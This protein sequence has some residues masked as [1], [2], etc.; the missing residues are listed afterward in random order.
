MIRESGLDN[1]IDVFANY[2]SKSRLRIK[3][4]VIENGAHI[5]TLMCCLRGSVSV[6]R[7]L[8]P[9]VLAT[10]V[11]AKRLC[12]PI[13]SKLCKKQLLLYSPHSPDKKKQIGG[14]PTKMPFTLVAE[15]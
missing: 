6:R 11:M 10:I 7:E 9:I 2:E 1:D 12:H 4:D 15:A 3:R 14:G 8:H 5:P 13:A